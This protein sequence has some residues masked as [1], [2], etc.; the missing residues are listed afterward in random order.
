MTV[1]ES[2]VQCTQHSLYMTRTEDG[3]GG[4]M[5]DLQYEPFSVSA[6]S[7][8][9]CLVLSTPTG[10]TAYVRHGER[11]FKMSCCFFL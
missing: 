1:N 2:A 6:L 10:Q 5:L 8:N 3:R 11:V 4:V 7:G 9:K